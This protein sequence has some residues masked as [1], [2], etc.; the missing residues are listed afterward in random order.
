M[1]F[2]YPV[3]NPC[4]EVVDVAADWGHEVFETTR[5]RELALK[6]P[7][8]IAAVRAFYNCPKIFSFD[9]ALADQTVSEFDL[10]L[11]SDIEYFKHQDIERWAA[12]NQIKNYLLALGGIRSSDQINPKN[13]LYRHHNINRYL[14][15]NQFVDTSGTNKPYLFDCLLGARRPHRDYVML[16]LT[17]TGLLDQSIVTYRAG[18][19][20][21]IINSYSN[22]YADFFSNTL[23]H[24]PY[25]SPNLDPDWE[26][27]TQVSNQVSCAAPDNIFRNTHYSI[28]CETLGTGDDFFLSEK[29]VKAMFAKRVFV[30]FGPRYFLKRLRDLGFETFGTVIDESYDNEP[31]DDIRFQQ[32]MLQVLK[33]AHFLDPG[34]VYTLTNHATEKNFSHLYQVQIQTQRMMNFLLLTK[35]P[36]HS[37]LQ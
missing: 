19:P 31:C 22:Q 8:S 7:F 24:W 18:F 4:V 1:K 30:I 34:E 26:V 6:Q 36:A 29:T 35:T 23:L 15:R 2:R 16:A 11:I 14:C 3:Y 12:E 9:P 13:M 5:D 25:I 20:G 28:V 21:E 32:A 37:W 17:R 27:G 33:L 10:V